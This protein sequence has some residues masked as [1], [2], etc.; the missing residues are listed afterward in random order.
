MKTFDVPLGTR[1]IY[2]YITYFCWDCDR[3]KT[4]YEC[5]SPVC[6]AMAILAGDMVLKG[7]Y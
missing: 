3:G 2:V 5:G 4:R 6:C 1:S 7:E